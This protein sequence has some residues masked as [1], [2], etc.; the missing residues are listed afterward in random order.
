MDGAATAIAHPIQGLVKYH[1]MRDDTLRLPYHPSISVCTAPSHSLTTVAFESDR[2]ADTYEIDGER[3]TGEGAERIRRVI[4]RI[5]TIAD[6]DTRVRLESRNDFPTNVGFGS[7]ASGFA[8]AACAAAAAAGLDLSLPELSAIARRG[9]ASAARAVTGGFSVLEAGLN[10][11]DCRSYRLD[12]PLES[13]LRIVAGIVPTY[14]ETG[15]AHAEAAESHMFQARLAHVHEQLAAVGI[16]GEAA[17]VAP[18][19]TAK[20][21]RTASSS[22]PIS[23]RVS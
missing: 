17:S 6:T 10:D 4:D 18:L 3:V 11:A 13:E 2:D 20:T 12:S 15:R 23:S 22:T 16:S 5:R 9:S 21:P 19:R 8:A 1:G 7:S 14:K